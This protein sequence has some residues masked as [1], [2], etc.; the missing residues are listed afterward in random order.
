MNAPNVLLIN[1]L[2]KELNVL[3]VQNNFNLLAPDILQLS[4]LLDELM[5]PLFEDQL[6]N[7]YFELY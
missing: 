7:S 3:V 1:K 5:L 2:K 6:D 4:K